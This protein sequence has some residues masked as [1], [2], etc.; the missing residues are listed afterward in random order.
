MVT[1]TIE[2]IPLRLRKEKKNEYDIVF[3]FACV[4]VRKKKTLYKC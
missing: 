4:E 3:M 2:K 1:N